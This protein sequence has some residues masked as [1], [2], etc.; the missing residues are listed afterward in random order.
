MSS[1][2]LHALKVNF[3]HR[4]VNVFHDLKKGDSFFERFFRIKFDAKLFSID[5]AKL[6]KLF[7]RYLHNVR[8]SRA[9][10]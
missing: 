9:C 1:T 7:R 2:F 10:S 3:S 6:L 8:S 5:R 4:L